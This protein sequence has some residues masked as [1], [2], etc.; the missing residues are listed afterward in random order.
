MNS[1]P[2]SVGSM[3]WTV[4]MLAVVGGRRGLRLAHEAL[5]GVLVVAP[6]AAAGTSARRAVRASCR[7]PCRR[8]PCAPPPRRART[9][10]WA[11]TESIS[12]SAIHVHAARSCRC[13]RS[14]PSGGARPPPRPAETCAATTGFTRPPRASGHTSR[15]ERRGDRAPSPRRCAAR[16]VD[17]VIVSRR[18]RTRR[19][20]IVA[21]GSPLHAGRSAPAGR[22][23][24]APPGCAAT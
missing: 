8:P 2:S 12:G 22:P 24:P 19:R 21:V 17:P 23:S 14:T 9:S 11:T 16:S 4:Q 18:P 3:S 20:S 10:Y 13:A 6:L 15:A 7:A 5:L 1:R